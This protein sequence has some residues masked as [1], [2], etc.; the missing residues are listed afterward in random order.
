ML[1]T[2]IRKPRMNK[3]HLTAEQRPEFDR[4]IKAARE[5]KAEYAQLMSAAVEYYSQCREGYS[6]RLL[7]SQIYGHTDL[8]IFSGQMIEDSSIEESILLSREDKQS[9]LVVAS[10]GCTAASLAASTPLSK[11]IVVDDNASNLAM[12]K[13]KL[14]LLESAIPSKRLILLGYMPLSPSMRKETLQHIFRELGFHENVFGPIDHVALCGAGFAGRLDSLL[15]AMRDGLK[16]FSRRWQYLLSLN[17][18]TSLADI[19]CQGQP[20]FDNLESAF[21]KVFDNDCSSFL[22]G[23]NS[24]AS[25]LA[26][27]NKIAKYLVNR[28]CSIFG[29]TSAL[30]N[31]FIQLM[32]GG[33]Y[34]KDNS[35][36]LCP[37]WLNCPSPS[38]DFDLETVNDQLE[39]TF[40]NLAPNSLDLISLSNKLDYFDTKTSANLVELSANA[41]KP[42]GKIV[43][44]SLSDHLPI[45]DNSLDSPILSERFTW[46]RS[47]D[48]AVIY[49]HAYVGE[50]L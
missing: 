38:Y 6:S 18:P 10:S 26:E 21:H 29:E 19:L 30:D 42:G 17:A 27:D 23:E 28:I 45:S 15:R 32:L 13:F 25:C 50:K 11:L 46:S 36:L 3:K 7:V 31:P 44:R 24:L 40:Q 34:R 16:P 41:L 33:K 49:S 37:A 5:K 4:L 2:S 47:A 35:A 48:R 12:A 20:L 8:P 22:F 43:I 39:N 9:A 1:H 14:H